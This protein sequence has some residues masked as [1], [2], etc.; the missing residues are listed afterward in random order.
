MKFSY[1][2]NEFMGL[3]PEESEQVFGFFDQKQTGLVV[4]EEFLQ[5]LAASS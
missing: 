3:T 2:L 4:I 5:G 1:I